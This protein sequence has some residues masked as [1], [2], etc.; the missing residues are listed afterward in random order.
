MD[1]A[2][3]VDRRGGQE[4]LDKTIVLLLQYP[5]EVQ[6]HC[7]SRPITSAQACEIFEAE[8]FNQRT[9]SKKCFVQLVYIH[10]LAL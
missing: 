3:I 9:W 7:L 10:V 6:G 1:K 4:D 8:D 2:S 5:K